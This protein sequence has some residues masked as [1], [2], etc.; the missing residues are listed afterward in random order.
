MARQKNAVHEALVNRNIVITAIV[1][2]LAGAGLTWCGIRLL[3]VEG[4]PKW[5]GELTKELGT[6]AF[7]IG[8]I[9]LMWELA[10]RR[11]FMSEIL[12]TV[13]ISDDIEEQGLVQIAGDYLR[14]PWSEMFT[15]TAAFDMFVSYGRTWT[16]A[17]AVHLQEMADRG[18]PMRI[19]FPDPGNAQVVAELSIWFR[20]TTEDLRSRISGSIS[21]F[22]ELARRAG[23]NVQIRLTTTSPLFT[24]YLFTRVVVF[25]TH[26]HRPLPAPVPTFIA[27]EG[28]ALYTFFRA[29]FEHLWG[30]ATPSQAAEVK[31][32]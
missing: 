26:S 11:A 3:E 22:G 7:G 6:A 16:S 25:T 13:D 27:K 28:K 29:E 5:V 14:V 30:N 4:C 2:V 18:V 21:K 1:I 12:A 23:A 19:M 17:N 15:E 8:I 9:A 31:K 24:M 10:A 20:T 32:S